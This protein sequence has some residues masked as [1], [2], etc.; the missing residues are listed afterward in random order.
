M[1][2]SNPIIKKME[3][4]ETELNNFEKII[5]TSNDK[6]TKKLISDYPTVYIHTWNGNK[7]CEVYV[8]ESNDIFRRTREHYKNSKAS[9]NWQHNLK[10]YKSSLYI[11]GHEYFNKSL[12]LD[13]ESKLI[14]Y[15]TCVE[16]VN[17][18]HNHNFNYQNKYYT[19]DLLDE[20]FSKIWR[21]LKGYDSDVFPLE[22]NITDSAIFK[23][24]PLHKLTKDQ[25]VAKDLI[26]SKIIEAS[27]NNKRGQLIFVE[28]EAGTGKTVLNSSTFYELCCINETSV[29]ENT[30]NINKKL[31][32]N[33][34]VNHKEQAIVYKQIFKKLCIDN[35][36][37]LVQTATSFINKHSPDDPIDV[38]FVDEAHLLL[39]QGKQ[40]YRGKNQLQDILDRAKVTIIMFDF[41]QILTSEQYWEY[42]VLEKYKNMAKEMNNYIVLK[43][44]LRIRAN[45]E[46]IKWIDDFTKN[47]KVNK[48]P[49]KLDDYDIKVF[50]TPFLLEKAINKQIKSKDSKLSRIIATYDWKYNDSKSNNGKMWE[51][52]IDK[53]H[54]PWNYEI[55]KT[56]TRKENI[57]IKNTSWAEQDHT[58]NEVGSTYTI[59]GFDLNYA[60]VIIGPSV[61]YR[62]GKIVFCP[63]CSC[64]S[65]AV[66]NRTLSNGKQENFGKILLKN[67]LRVLMTRGVNG[68]YIYAYDEELRNHL[69]KCAGKRYVKK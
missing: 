55:Q 49:K 20:V 69:R 9:K 18:V 50:D 68:L 25:Q 56:F 60:G 23:A 8:G 63:E 33:L 48:I 40:S 35:D 24:S 14:Q 39:T 7:G 45:D 66:R 26:L 21:N 44:Q 30:S 52:S 32:C 58:I 4:N 65:K 37:T 36:G 15:L 22:S 64:N 53:W 46:V 43:E 5:N 3:D 62:D 13:I 2:L 12:T 27:L 28:G 17:K 59:Q 29:N 10:K 47:G 41:N 67:E 19:S 51:V 38:A 54:K 34:L 57:K 61:K 31:K 1:I 42:E 16:N 6:K 11:I